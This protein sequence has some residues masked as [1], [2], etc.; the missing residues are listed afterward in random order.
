MEDHIERSTLRP[1]S[2]ESGCIGN[3]AT[4]DMQDGVAAKS[5]PGFPGELLKLSST[6]MRAPAGEQMF[7]HPAA[8]KPGAAGD[9]VIHGAF[10]PARSGRC[11]SSNWCTA[12]RP[13]GCAAFDENS[14]SVQRGLSG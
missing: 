12:T 2:V 11:F 7:D 10:L 8:N 6:V 4:N 3:V 1:H 13:N 14:L 9:E 5:R